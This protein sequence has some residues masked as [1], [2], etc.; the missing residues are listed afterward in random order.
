METNHR[1]ETE[2]AA[3]RELSAGEIADVSGAQYQIRFGNVIF[4]WNDRGCY[5]IWNAKDKTGPVSSGCPGE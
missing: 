1:I 4:Q 5:A 3:L 2:H